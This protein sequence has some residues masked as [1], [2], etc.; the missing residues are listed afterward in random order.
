MRIGM[1][2]EFNRFHCSHSFASWMQRG[3]MVRERNNWSQKLHDFQY[4]WPK[5]EIATSIG[6]IALTKSSS[7][8]SQRKQTI[9]KEEPKKLCHR[10]TLSNK[11]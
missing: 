8:S 5:A 4:E 1:A 9:D 6:V 10:Q 3:D 2:I 7:S 11:Q